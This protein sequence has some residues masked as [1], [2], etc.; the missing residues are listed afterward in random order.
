MLLVLSVNEMDY[1]RFH[2]FS[3]YIRHSLYMQNTMSSY[4]CSV[5]A[6]LHC[7]GSHLCMSRVTQLMCSDGGWRLMEALSLYVATGL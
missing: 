4:I 5:G 2:H 6:M 7:T 1:S 3:P